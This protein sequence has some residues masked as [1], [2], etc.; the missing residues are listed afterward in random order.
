MPKLLEEVQNILRSRHYS[1]RTEGSYLD[2]IR[3]YIILHG[4][5]HPAEMGPTEVS[6]SLTHLT[7]NRRVAAS[8]QNRALPALLFVY[9]NLLKQDLPWLEDVE[10]RECQAACL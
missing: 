3:Q 8:T 2:W 6:K 10:R 1:Y 5:R 4:K 7:I 9:R